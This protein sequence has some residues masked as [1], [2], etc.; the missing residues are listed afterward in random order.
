MVFTMIKEQA[1]ILIKANHYHK[2]LFVT[3]SDL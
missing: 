1:I 2:N 3:K